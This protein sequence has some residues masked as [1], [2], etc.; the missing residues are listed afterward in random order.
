M[1]SALDLSGQT[2]LSGQ[3]DMGV[4]E[5]LAG[6]AAPIYYV[7]R[8]GQTPVSPYTNGW[9]AAA[10]NIQDVISVLSDGATVLVKSGVYPLTNQIS[11]G[12]TTL[13][14]DNNG[15][16]DRDGTIINGN[17]PNATNRCF[18]LNHDEALVEGF[19]ITNGY[20]LGDGGGVYLTNGTLRNCLVTGNTASN[21]SGGG[22]YASGINSRITNCDIVYN[23]CVFSGAPTYVSGGGGVKLASG[24]SLWNSRIMYNNSPIYWSAGGGV[25]CDPGSMV[26][27]CKIISNKVGATYAVGTAYGGGG[28]WANGNTSTQ[29][30]C[31][32]MGNGNGNLD[33]GAGIGTQGGGA[34]VESCTIAGNF[35]SGIWGGSGT[36]RVLNTIS[37]GNSGT[38]VTSGGGTLIASNCCV[39]T[40]NFVTGGSGN[41]TNNPLFV[42]IAGG[43]CRLTAVSPCIDV[44]ANQA[45]M[46]G[47]VDLDGKL[48]I[49]QS[50]GRVDMGAY[51]LDYIRWGSVFTIR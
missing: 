50:G 44:G 46:S 26:A 9:S 14:S 51:E 37:Y 34:V 11:I 33:R 5:T 32:I 41:I 47:A 45:G 4:Y 22:V 28:I 20:A 35:G 10:S 8:S 31:L 1:S 49:W 40:T 19:T 15:T 30:N 39:A 23:S 36:Y 48:R 18:T 25:N 3:P 6:G 38:D 16:V 27:Y 13:R 12:F 21:G 24:A 2:R 42:N 17:F 29:L 7:A 43:D